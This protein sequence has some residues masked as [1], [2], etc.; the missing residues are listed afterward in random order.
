[1]VVNLENSMNYERWVLFIIFFL[2]FK[3]ILLISSSSHNDNNNFLSLFDTRPVI[4]LTKEI[5]LNFL[6]LLC[7]LVVLHN[8]HI[9]THTWRINWNQFWFFLI[10]CFELWC[11]NRKIFIMYYMIIVSSPFCKH[12]CV[13]S[14]SVTFCA[15]IWK[16]QVVGCLL[17]NWFLQFFVWDLPTTLLIDRATGCWNIVP[18]LLYSRHRNDEMNLCLSNAK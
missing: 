18:L 15:V 4:S 10:W 12:F 1:M 7:F 14:L 16:N 5:V 2:C 3:T 6:F 17:L 13:T 9:Q 8:V 11:S